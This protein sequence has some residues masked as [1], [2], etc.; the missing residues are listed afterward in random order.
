MF[1][2]AI[3]VVSLK[4]LLNADAVRVEKQKK[5]DIHSRTD[6]CIRTGL[7]SASQQFAIS[8]I[9]LREAEFIRSSFQ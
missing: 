7:Q 3:V 2:E 8:A 4:I 9:S 6:S 1:R 5:L